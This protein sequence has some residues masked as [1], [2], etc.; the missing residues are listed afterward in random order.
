VAA[1]ALDFDTDPAEL[2]EITLPEGESYELLS[3]EDMEE[4]FTPKEEEIHAKK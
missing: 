4:L 2:P 3:E 1:V